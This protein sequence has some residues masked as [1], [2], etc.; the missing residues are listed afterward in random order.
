M[1]TKK[2]GEN[3]TYWKNRVKINTF[4]VCEKQFLP[5]A[6]KVVKKQTF[7]LWREWGNKRYYIILQIVLCPLATHTHRP[8]SWAPLWDISSFLSFHPFSSSLHSPSLLSYLFQVSSQVVYICKKILD[9]VLY[10][11]RF[12]GHR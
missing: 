7:T 2:V 5:E 3:I 12:R 4:S 10:I 11:S 8:I 6:W 1:F 9:F